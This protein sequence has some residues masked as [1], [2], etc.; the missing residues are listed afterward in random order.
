LRRSV[1]VKV[2]KSA[3]KASKPAKTQ[4]AKAEKG[5][6]EKKV[7]KFRGMKGNTLGLPAYA[8]WTYLF[9]MQRKIADGKPQ[10]LGK[11]TLKKPLTDEQI[12]E[13]LQD[14]FDGKLK[15]GTESG[16]DRLRSLYNRGKINKQ[17]G[18]PKKPVG[19]FDEKGEETIRTRG[20]GGKKKKG[21]EDGE[22]KESKKKSKTKSKTKAKDEEEEEE[23]E[24]DEESEEE[25]EEEE[26]EE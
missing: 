17:D 18:P 11:K 20:M 3:K 2:V 14:E 24:E 12:V 10:T 19:E 25:E 7:P 4:S 15:E 8:T 21:D 22:G 26:D 5:D 23:E 1:V 16:V 13:F 6:G 9:D